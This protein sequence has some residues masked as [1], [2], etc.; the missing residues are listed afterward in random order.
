MK[1]PKYN[2]LTLSNYVPDQQTAEHAPQTLL[3]QY[4][5]VMCYN[6]SAQEKDVK[7]LCHYFN[8]YVNVQFISTL[9]KIVCKDLKPQHN[10]TYPQ[11]WI[12]TQA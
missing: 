8:R 2:F 1:G 12:F 5:Q 7:M 9:C 6:I 10:R 3:S 4:S 11:N